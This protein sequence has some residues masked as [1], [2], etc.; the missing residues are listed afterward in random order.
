MTT[1]FFTDARNQSGDQIRRSQN[2]YVHD[3][4]HNQPLVILVTQINPV[5]ALPAY[6]FKD[7]LRIFA[8]PTGFLTQNPACI[9]RLLHTRHMPID[10]VLLDVV[11]RIIHD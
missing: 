5:Q 9:S 3:R 6:L 11:T 1:V 7:P 2:T 10:P 4:V 8:Y